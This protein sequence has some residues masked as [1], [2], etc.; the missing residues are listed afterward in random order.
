MQNG[1]LAAFKAVKHGFSLFSGF[2][3]LGKE[4]FDAINDA[5]LIV[6][7]GEGER[8]IFNIV[9]TNRR[10]IVSFHKFI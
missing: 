8:E 7:R 3:Q 10:R 4:G 6:E 9:F 5:L 2:V 1:G